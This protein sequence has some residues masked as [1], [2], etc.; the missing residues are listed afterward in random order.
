MFDK[1]K[2]KV[3]KVDKKAL[4]MAIGLMFMSWM[5]LPIVYFLLVRKKAPM[6][7]VKNGKMVDEVETPARL[8]AEVGKDLEELERCGMS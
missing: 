8:A 1:L 2:D 7:E 6:K 5:A 3:G 4:S